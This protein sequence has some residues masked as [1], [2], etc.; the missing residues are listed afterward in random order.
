MAGHDARDWERD[1]RKYGK[2]VDRKVGE[3]FWKWAMKLAN[4]ARRACPVATG[5]GRASIHGEVGR[6]GGLLIGA[7]GTN[8]KH[9]VFVEFGTRPHLIEPK[10]GK[11]L[12]FRGRDGSWVFRRQVRHPGIKVGTPQS[13]RTTWP[14]K[15]ATGTRAGSASES[16][17]FMRVAWARNRD[18]LLADLKS[19]GIEVQ[20]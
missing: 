20:G 12:R 10:R 9:L 1:I 16:M 3:K 7:Y 17:P 2:A 11:M 4:D 15:E 13:P 19:I 8:E 18:K 6:R 5:E 14:A